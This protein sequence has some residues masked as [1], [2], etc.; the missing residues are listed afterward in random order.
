[1][2]QQ[3]LREEFTNARLALANKFLC[4][5]ADDFRNKV[6]T[7]RAVYMYKGADPFVGFADPSLDNV[8]QAEVRQM[9]GYARLKA[10]CSAPDMD[11]CLGKPY[12]G[13]LFPPSEKSPALSG[14]R[15]RSGCRGDGR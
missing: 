13:Y 7:E 9:E 2:T 4:E 10:A 11:M 14:P 15:Q 5:L 12:K 8:S 3:S 6:K 1:M